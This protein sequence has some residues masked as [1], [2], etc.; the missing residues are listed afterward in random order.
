MFIE[1]DNEDVVMND[2]PETSEENLEEVTINTSNDEETQDAVQETETNTEDDIE[3]RIEARANE[4]ME[5]K[6]KDRIARDRA[7]QERKFNKKLAKYKHLES[8][9]NAGLGVDNLDEAISQASSFYKE[10]G[11]DIPEYTESFSESDEKILAEAY[12]KEIIDLG[13]DEMKAEANR[14]ASIPA[15]QR[16]IRE[17]TMFDILCKELM[18]LKDI[19]ELKSKGYKTDILKTKEFSQFRDQFNVNTP[20]STIYEMYNKMNGLEAKQ[21]A[22]PGSAKTNTSINEIKEYY[23]PEEA[24]QFTEEDFERNPKLMEVIEKSMLQWGKSK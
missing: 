10:Q 16:S 7:S 5:E 6:I 11:I 14:I 13:K 17:K 19:D 12:A 4:L 8:V 9:M 22:S 20:I 15:E 24:R 23:T 2:V 3:E 1:N 21:P 18:N